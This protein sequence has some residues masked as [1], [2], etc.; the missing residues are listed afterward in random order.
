MLLVVAATSLLTAGCG[1][2]TPMERFVGDWQRLR[3]GAADPG[4]TLT[5]EGEGTAAVLTFADAAG[6]SSTADAVLA[7]DVLS[8]GL[9][10]A[11]GEGPDRAS[12]ATS[13]GDPL[14]AVPAVVPVELSL[15]E[16]GE[17]LSVQMVAPG[18]QLVPLW[19]YARTPGSE[20][21]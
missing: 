5:I 16:A 1:T 18:D 9:P 19:R 7:G 21:E 20:A 12:P 2:D 8:C 11:E 4:H 15:D 17:V 10:A 13:P 6:T 3:S 14:E